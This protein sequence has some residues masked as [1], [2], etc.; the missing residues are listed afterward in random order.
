MVLREA[1][2]PIPFSH[3]AF[4]EAEVKGKEDYRYPLGVAACQNVDMP[5]LFDRERFSL[6]Y[7]LVQKM[8]F[9]LVVNG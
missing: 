8:A 6:P 5:A 2:S 1:L 3:Q 4:P 9:V 7:E